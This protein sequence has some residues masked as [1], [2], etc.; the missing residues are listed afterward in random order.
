MKH[1]I[2]RLWWQSLH[3]LPLS[4]ISVFLISANGDKGLPGMKP[5]VT[6]E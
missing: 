4:A 1:D 5:Q 2:L 3:K 6:S